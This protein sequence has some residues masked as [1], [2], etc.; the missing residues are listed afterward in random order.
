MNMENLSD[1]NKNYK[2][3]D[4]KYKRN[5]YESIMEM[6]SV[7]QSLETAIHRI[8]QFPEDGY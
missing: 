1:K 5:K 3:T 6:A 4:D 7:V 2:K 8:N